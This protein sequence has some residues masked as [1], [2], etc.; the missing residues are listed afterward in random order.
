MKTKHEIVW[1]SDE[2]NVFQYDP[3]NPLSDYYCVLRGQD[4]KTCE[5]WAKKNSQFFTGK[6]VCVR[7][8]LVK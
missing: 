4:K 6:L 1:V 2:W 7:R 3:D 5:T 8:A